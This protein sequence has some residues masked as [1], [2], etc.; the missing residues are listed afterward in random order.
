MWRNMFPSIDIHNVVLD[1]IKRCVLLNYDAESGTIEFRHYAIKV[2][3]VG[4]TN[5]VRKIITGKKVPDLGSYT[6]VEE[7]IK[8]GEIADFTES[9]G[10]M[11][12][13]D[14]TRHVTLPQQLAK[15]GNLR[16]ETSAIRFVTIFVLLKFLFKF[17]FLF[18]AQIG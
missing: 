3:P 7:A 4:L 17:L 11:D 15:R 18:C 16:D 8:R 5:T 13:V 2:K 14:E 12:E 9:E 6:S 1:N 10:E